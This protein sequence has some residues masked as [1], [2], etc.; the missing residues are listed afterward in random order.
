MKVALVHD[1]LV[2]Y[3]GGEKVLEALCAL[4]PEAELFTLIHEPGSMPATIEQ[5]RIH[6]SFIDRLPLARRRHRQ[7]LPLFPKAIESL[8]LEGFELVISSSHCVAKGVRK[9]RRAKHLSYVHA[10]MRYM[11]DRFDDYFGPGR[12][13]PSVRA[14]ALAL[15]PW[16]QRW[17]VRS[18]AGV[19]RFVSN[20]H[21]IAQ[22]V[23][24]LYG[25][26]SS[27][28]Y[29]PVEL[30]RFTQVPLKRPEKGGYYLWLGALAPYKRVDLAIEA[31]RATGEPL[32]IAGSGQDEHRLARG[33]PPN[34]RYLGQVSD[35]Q[36][37]ELY[38]GARAF[39][40]TGEEDFGLTPLEAQAC[41]TPVI[42]Y[43]RGGVLETVTAQ[44]GVLFDRQTPEA[45]AEA[46]HAFDRWEAGFEPEAARAQ[47]QRFSRGAFLTGIQREVDALLAR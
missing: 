26:Q 32:W 20:S 40:F 38:R 9:P 7:F 4:F 10:P 34:V 31:F 25:R 21:H 45:L 36:M 5:R 44:T 37:P 11:W 15:R 16:L 39:I 33:L 19:D 43:G 17:D 41:G 28:V 27:V 8:S 2:T 42:A 3:R 24:Q 30:D 46:V 29:P 14:A 13:A 35:G 23:A 6:T 12:A 1:W 47:A 18:S 22:K